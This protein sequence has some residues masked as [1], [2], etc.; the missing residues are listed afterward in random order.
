MDCRLCTIPSHVAQNEQIKATAI[1]PSKADHDN[2]TP[3]LSKRSVRNQSW[4]FKITVYEETSMS[5]K[6]KQ[7]L[8]MALY[9]LA[10]HIP[11]TQ[12]A[13][14]RRKLILLS[15]HGL[16]LILP[17]FSSWGFPPLYFYNTLCLDK[18][19]VLNLGATLQFIHLVNTFLRIHCSLPL[20]SIMT[21]VND[22]NFLLPPAAR[23]PHQ[24]PL[25]TNQEESKAGI[26]FNIRRQSAPFLWFFLMWVSN[27]T[28]STDDLLQ[29]EVKLEVWNTFLCTLHQLK[30]QIYSIFGRNI[31]SSLDKHLAGYL[32][33]MSVLSFTLN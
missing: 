8:L 17:S 3:R 10:P 20:P 11:S 32:K 7:K 1:N 22:R 27:I 30:E 16:P 24:M 18:W 4:Q 21:I 5:Y 15:A 14:T 25:T 2:R 29:W 13:S 23:L 28:L 31:C 9:N 19:Q 26:W 12:L 33:L 6:F